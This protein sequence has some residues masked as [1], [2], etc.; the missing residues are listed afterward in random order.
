[1][2]RFVR[3]GDIPLNEMS[4]VYRGETLIGHE[5]GVSVYRAMKVDK[6]WHII[7]PSPLRETTILTLLQ[8]KCMLETGERKAFLCE[9]NIVGEGHDGEPLLKNVKILKDI[10]EDIIGNL[11]EIKNENS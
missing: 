3:I 9:G 11:K 4:G 7:M 5:N 10:S 2:E 8:M 6:H 1:M